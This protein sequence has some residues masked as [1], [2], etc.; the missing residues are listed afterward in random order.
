MKVKS[1]AETAGSLGKEAS[2]YL[3][4]FKNE[5]VLNQGHKDTQVRDS[6]TSDVGNPRKQETISA[7]R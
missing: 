7:E 5:E 6:A 3:G 1:P 4:Q 2:E